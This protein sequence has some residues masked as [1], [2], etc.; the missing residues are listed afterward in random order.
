MRTE[1]VGTFK[2]AAGNNF[3]TI[4]TKAGVYGMILVNGVAKIIGPGVDDKGFDVP[5]AHIGRLG[6]IN[7]ELVIDYT[8]FLGHMPGTERD[9]PD[10]PWMRAFTGIVCGAQVG[11]LEVA[12]IQ[13]GPKGGI[14]PKGDSIKGDPGPRGGGLLVGKGA[15]PADF[16]QPGDSYFDAETGNV[17]GRT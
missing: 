7:G 15:P 3:A 13:T 11:A 5:Q 2:G 6:V 10:R 4:A 1:Q 16:G 9:N 12:V 14:G 8:M 17:Y